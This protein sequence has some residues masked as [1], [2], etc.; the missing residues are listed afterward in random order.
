[1]VASGTDVGPGLPIYEQEL[2]NHLEQVVRLANLLGV[3]PKECSRG[4]EKPSSIWPRPV[5]ENA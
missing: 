5:K 1:M 3:S 4:C 2:A